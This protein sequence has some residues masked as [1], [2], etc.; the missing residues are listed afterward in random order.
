MAKRPVRPHHDRPREPGADSAQPSDVRIIGGTFR[1]RRLLYGGQLRTRPM[2]D[3][4]R[5]AVFNLL[6][7]AVAGKHAVDLFAGTGALGIEALSRGAASAT[8]I[9]QHFPTA[10]VL[11]QNLRMLKVEDRCQIITGNAFLWA[12]RGF[13]SG[14]RPWVVLLSPLRL[15]RGASRRHAAVHWHAPRLRPGGKPV[16]GRIRRTLRPGHAPRPHPMGCPPLSASGRRAAGV[17]VKPQPVAAV[18]WRCR[19]RSPACFPQTAPPRRS[20]SWVLVFRFSYFSQSSDNTPFIRSL[21][22][23][24]LN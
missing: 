13:A 17:V 24:D 11:L 3:R 14:G 6:G 18:A 20:P 15:L 4:V 1:G 2:K 8:F 19:Y 5:E 21:Q 9:E 7:T 10:D 16:G 12:Q 22:T 23:S